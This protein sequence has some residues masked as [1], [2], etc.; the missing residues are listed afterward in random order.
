MA[1][2]LVL[3]LLFALFVA[4]VPGVAQTKVTTPMEQFGH[5]IGDDYFLPTYTQLVEYWQKL[6]G[7][8][9]RMLLDTIG[10]TAEGRPQLMAIVSSPEN[11]RNLD[12]IKAD[13]KRLALANDLTDDQ[14]RRLSREAKAVAWI[15]GGLHA[16]EVLG[17]A[18]L[19]EML[20]QLVSM[21]DEETLR[22]LNDEVILLVHANPDGMELVS[23]WYMR[24]PDPLKRSTGGIPRLYQKY[25]GHDDNRDSY[26]VTQPETENI[27]R[28]MYLEWY[29][30]VMYN[31]H[32]TGPTGTVL[33]APPF[34]DPHNYWFHPLISLGVDAVGT[35]M[36][37]RLVA[38][39]KPGSTMRSGASYSTWFNGGVR[40]T[41]YFH[42]IIGILTEASG[43]PT[44]M[45]IAFVPEKT[46]STGD[47]PAP[48]EP[49]EWHFRQ[50]VD[51]SISLDRAF[52]DYASR[53][54]EVLLYNRYQMGRD[55]IRRGE[56]DSWTIH[57]K[58]V[59]KVQ[60]EIAA[61][62][63]A[64]ANPAAAPA[65][66]SRGLP[67]E[68]FQA[69]RK[70]EDRDPRG[71]I[72]PSN[73][74]DFLTAVKF[75]NTLV[76]NGVEI[77]RATRDFQVMGKSY[78]AGSLVVK[79]AQAYA[80]HIYD[81][82]EPQDHPNDFEYPGGPPIPP[83]DN[84]G[85]TLAL[86]MGVQFDRIL[87]GFDGPFEVV[88]GVVKAP[89][90][91]VADGNGAAGYLLSHQVNDAVIAT[92]RLLA[93]RQ[94]VYWLSN[95]VTAAGTSWPAGTIYIP[96]KSASRPIVEKLAVELGLSFQ[97]V[98]TTPVADA[99][100]LA[101]VRVGL[102]DQYGG[103]MPSG[104][105]RWMFEQWE[106]PFQVVFAPELDRG[107]LNKK[108]DVLVFE[109]GG[110]PEARGD[111]APARGPSRGPDPST[112]PAE[113]RDWL[114]SVTPQTTVPNLLGFVRSGG[115]LLA[116]GGS[117]SIAAHA[118]LPVTNHL[119]DAQGKPLSPS[120]YYI[121][122][123]LLRVRVDNT[124]PVAY[125]MPDHATVMFDNSP[126]YDLGPGAAAAG[127]TRVGWFDSPEPLLSGWAWG[128]ERLN[129]GTAMMDV[130]LGQGRM[131]L[132]GPLIKERAQPHGTFK[133]LFNG[134]QL[135]RA[136]PVKLGGK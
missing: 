78:P 21:D 88:D 33:F 75:V 20:Y 40:T 53:Y 82:F 122:S 77:Q 61:R 69:F 55:A 135:G 89:A 127:I 102:W 76:K 95:E 60:A 47:L 103:S 49:Q 98:P 120:Q 45:E 132:F 64:G 91:T 42:N 116:I 63:G 19:M 121:P 114:G 74:T 6:A 81:M 54:K 110:I 10:V 4:P 26:M 104:W 38:E 130:R 29:P 50:A 86:Q 62:Q 35:A 126:V 133:L 119:V 27:G 107:S 57:P 59:A 16:T 25:I 5:N 39:G 70:P 18:Q 106:V 85:Y 28:V 87:D 72:L 73:Q 100:E 112:I 129:G 8:S 68:G 65:G 56:T 9:P 41:T 31:H 79:T 23:S 44:P 11:L 109:D 96:A 67:K 17:A 7:E 12:K 84:A 134:I 1:L 71:Y 51:Y 48:I 92:N 66:R 58:T 115:T 46:I 123:S 124:Q 3:A 117:T 30:Q 2:C 97:G 105:A 93:A 34:R 94:E 131:F 32:Q 101:P 125:G 111:N 36:H 15:D 43:N 37:G 24:E 136:T 52:L 22:L 14:A 118:G 108:F 90:G 128:Q 99:L 113:Y 80:P 83:Y 13:A